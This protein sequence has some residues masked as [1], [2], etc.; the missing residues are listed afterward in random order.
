M[1]FELLCKILNFLKKILLWR[2]VSRVVLMKCW[3]IVSR[4]FL[5]GD[6]GCLFLWW[7]FCL[8][9]LWWVWYRVMVICWFCGCVLLSLSLKLCGCRSVLRVWRCLMS[10][11]G[12]IECCLSMLFV[13]ILVL[14]VLMRLF[15]CLMS[16]CVSVGWGLIVEIEGVDLWFVVLVCVC[17]SDMYWDLLF[18]CGVVWGLLLVVVGWV[19][20]FL[21]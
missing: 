21:L 19:F 14:C 3:L 17:D 4:W 11:C 18:Y 2:V 7:W 5:W 12:V 13:R 1:F 16:G 15:L 9:L 20:D 8:V 10:C 6:V